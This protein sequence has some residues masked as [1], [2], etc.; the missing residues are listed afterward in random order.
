MGVDVKDNPKAS[1][2]EASVE[3]KICV[4]DYQLKSSTLTITH[5]GVPKE[6][7]GRGIAKRMM[8]FV[9]ADAKAKKLTIV[10][11]CSYAAAY[12]ERRKA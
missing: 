2:Y 3:D 10:P 4:V 6:L 9:V 8:D 11:V 12:M 1:R 5:V 7:E